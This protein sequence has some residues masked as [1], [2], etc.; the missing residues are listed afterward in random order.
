MRSFLCGSILAMALAAGPG[1]AAPAY[2]LTKTVP[3]GAPDRWD[4]VV[5]DANSG[6]VLVAH[7]DKLSVV[8]GRAGTLLGQVEGITGG[9]HGAAA[10]S[11]TGEAFTDD[12]RNGLAV[13][14]DPKTF[15]VTKRIAVDKD[16]DG[17]AM[18]RASGHLFIVEGDPGKIAVIDPKTDTLAATIT[19]GEGME[20][21][22]SDDAGSLYVAGEEKSDLLRIDTA[23]N[24]I[25][26]RW[27]M[28]DCAKPHGVAIDKIGRRVFMGCVNSVMMVVDA[29]TG[30]LVAKLPI[31]KGSDAIVFDAR[32][33]RVLSPNGFDGTISVYRQVAPDQYQPLETIRTAITARTMAVDPASGRLFLAA[34]DSDPSPT[35]G[36]RAVP[37]AGTVKLMVFDP[38]D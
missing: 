16:A 3:L 9:T 34:A 23:S 4:Y 35:P 25:T 26:A 10:P 21:A 31:G 20:F 19:A 33:G 24:K 11:P 8:D 18:D 7:G 12:G 22:A 13:A 28:P 14:F 1:L 36:G 2:T 15:K 32:R 38:V 37:R 6:R 29:D 27:P 17:M 5:F 30:R